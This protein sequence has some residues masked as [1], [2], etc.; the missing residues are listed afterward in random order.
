LI[1][2][3]DSI[4]SVAF[5]NP[6]YVAC[7]PALRNSKAPLGAGFYYDTISW[8]QEFVRALSRAFF[9]DDLCEAFIVFPDYVEYIG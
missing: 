8:E 9:A 6:H 4:C 7:K 2:N 1:G 3:L 5:D